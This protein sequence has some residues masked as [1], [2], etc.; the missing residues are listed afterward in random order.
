MP[1]RCPLHT[2]RCK[3]GECLP[4]YEFCNAIITCRDGSDEPPHICGT[5]TAS[6]FILR[7]LSDTTGTLAKSQRQPMKSQSYCP[8]RCSNG[9]CRSTAIL[10]SGRDGCGDGTDEET[11][12]VCRKCCKYR[13]DFVNILFMFSYRMS[14]SD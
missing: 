6:N 8:F 5:K 14:S 4:E 1:Y 9:K 11:C 3:S 10:C 7:L 2:F 13:F 12:S